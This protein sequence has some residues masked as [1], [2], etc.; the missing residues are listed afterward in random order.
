LPTRSHTWLWT[1]LGVA[2]LLLMMTAEIALS[3][4]Q[5]SLS[6]D[7]GDHIYAGYMS[8]KEHD[9]SLNPEHPPLAKMVAALPLIG[10]GLKDQ[11]VPNPFFKSMAYYS[12][13]QMLFHNG[14]ADGGRYPADTLIFR[15]HMAIM[16]FMLLLALQTFFAGREM[17]GLGAGF[18]AMTLVVFEPSMLTNAPF[19]TT[20]ATVSCM[21]F[22]SIYCFYRY[23]KRPTPLRLLLTGLA[24]GLTLASKHSAILLLPMLILLSI[25]ELAGKWWT[26]RSTTNQQSITK[27]SLRMLAALAVIVV[28]AVTVLWAFYCFRFS[29]RPD[30]SPMDPPLAST[31]AGLVPFESKAIL[32][33][34]KWHILPESYLYGLVDVHNVAYWMPSYIFGKL[35]AH[36]VWF[37]FPTVLAIKFTLGAAG[38]LALSVW[39]FATGRMKK[40]R[41]VWFLFVPVFIYLGVAISSPLNIGVRHIL[42]TFAF[43]LTLAAGGAW[44]LIQRDKRWAYAVAVLLL[45][46][47]GSSAHA[48]P[49][50]M[51]YANELWGGPSHTHEYLSDSATDWGQELKATKIY[52]DQHHITDCWFA[53]FPA[54][55]LLPSDYGIPC[56]LLPTADTQGELD[57]EVPPIIHGPILIA[58]AD[59]NGFEFG[60]KVRNPY[61][62]F[63]E[64]KPDDVIINGIA[65]YNG[66]YSVPRLAAFQHLENAHQFLDKKDPAASL[67]EALKALSLD[68]TSFDGQL[69]AGDA[70]H[71][72]NRGVEAR[73]HYN[74]AMNLVNNMEPTSQQQWRPRIQKKIDVL[75]VP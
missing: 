45:W 31:A 7:E 8:L 13:R 25:G 62:N 50:Y 46:H 16:V 29:M 2:A 52:I 11:R 17:F 41:E 39:A 35:Y 59:L 19:V 5:E 22:A 37:Y 51:P 1:L 15:A 69:A 67:Q 10:L 63:F 56:K 48:F 61:Q 6:W 57:I 43:M 34:A 49:N 65:V 74:A 33:F 28:L 53:Y 55:F 23:V 26:N 72:L 32:F 70:L 44:T 14:P 40:A 54:P 68:P 21:F 4:R 66:T 24:A 36:G 42:P 12:G 58:Y 71:E 38:L 27:Q 9:Y 60:T 75:S 64:Q 3:S 18:I 20:D 47:A 30:G 73:E